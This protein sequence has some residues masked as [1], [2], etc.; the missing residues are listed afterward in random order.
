MSLAVAPLIF[1]LLVVAIVGVCL[2]E[3]G[4]GG[5]PKGTAPHCRECGFDLTGLLTPTPVDG[6]PVTRCPECGGDLT[7][8]GAVTIGRH[9]RRPRLMVAGLLLILA[10]VGLCAVAAIASS[11]DPL[12]LK[13][14]WML[15]SQC[16]SNNAWRAGEA[17][18]ELARRHAGGGL[19]DAQLLRTF[20]AF[21]SQ[22]ELAAPSVAS[23]SWRALASAAWDAGLATSA[24]RDRY[25]RARLSNFY[26]LQPRIR[27]IYLGDEPFPFEEPQS[28]LHPD[29]AT[30][31][32]W[33]IPG[34]VVGMAAYLD[35][36]TLDGQAI[37]L[38][39][40][41]HGKDDGEREGWGGWW[42]TF[43]T[44]TGNASG[45]SLLPS[46]V[47]VI[48]QLAPGPGPH[49]LDLTWRVDAFLLSP[50]EAD[51]AEHPFRDPDCSWS[52]T[53]T[54]AFQVI[55]AIEEI[56]SLVHA[57]G[58]G[59]PAPPRYCSPGEGLTLTVT[60]ARKLRRD[61]DWY[62]SIEG[63]LTR[64]AA[65]AGAGYAVLARVH[66]EVDGIPYRVAGLP[67]ISGIFYDRTDCPPVDQSPSVRSR[68]TFDLRIIDL[69]RVDRVDI[70]L[71]P[72]PE[73]LVRQP[74]WYGMD[75]IWGDPIV[76][77]DVPIDWTSIP[78]P[79]GDTDP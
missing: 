67:D 43:G 46:R 33:L 59:A 16:R 73:M 55:R 21:L 69:P 37:E 30:P 57:D 39:E 68:T 58:P 17:A 40:A 8:R 41:W 4:R 54:H 63:T 10:S 19:S 15:L 35:G 47:P 25:L 26:R 48:P 51:A 9:R 44:P 23:D 22:A 32:G 27:D 77:R 70:V 61:G 74:D 64:L 65:T 42:R 50:A 7:G 62:Y 75:P 79:D 60:S 56:V 34:R 52:A 24:H 53:T 36:A 71:T 29:P 3:V 20:D 72:A 66:L 13:P 28:M 11:I 14:T 12:S 38:D 18:Q 5:R 1:I 76:I 45:P 49:E 2:F 31:S 6:E 78:V